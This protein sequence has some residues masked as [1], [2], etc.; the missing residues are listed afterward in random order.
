[1]TRTK[2]LCLGDLHLGV[3]PSRV[4][5]EADPAA[6]SVA[7]VWRRAVETALREGVGLVLLSGDVVDRANRY[8]EA[9]G[10]LEESLARLAEAGVEVCA[11]AGN[12]DFDVLPRLAASAGSERFHLLGQDGR[13]ERFTWRR[14]DGRALV[15]VDGWSFAARDVTDDPVAS[16]DL[17]RPGDEAPVLG[18]LHGELDREDSTNAPLTRVGLERPEVDAWVLGHLHGPRV[19]DLAGGRWAL[20]PGSLQP[21]D[22][23]EEGPHGGWIVELDGAR[24][25][26]PELLPLATV[27]WEC[28]ELDLGGAAD[29]E[30]AEGRIARAVRDEATALDEEE[31]PGVDWL[32]LRLVLSGRTAAHRNLPELARRLEEDAPL[33]VTTRSGRAR[34]VEV[35][36]ATRP[37]P[38]LGGLAEGEGPV[39]LLASLLLDLEGSG[40]GAAGAERDLL[41]A[42]RDRLGEVYDQRAYLPLGGRGELDGDAVRRHAAAGAADLLDALLVAK[43]GPARGAGEDA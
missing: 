14:G 22:P 13:W 12:H 3:R 40:S 43:A 15:H 41:A 33:E 38:D 20:Y 27:R 17:E 4:P 34:V 37:A 29:P 9:F 23:T 5:A 19:I 10:P 18:L 16:Y 39:A 30:E 31:G 32:C 35:A 2:I 24:P 6:V 21:L 26:R 8:F 42:V 7:T 25:G 36:C 28:L 11:V 1:M